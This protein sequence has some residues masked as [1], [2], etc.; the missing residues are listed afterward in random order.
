MVPLRNGPGEASWVSARVLLVASADCQAVNIAVATTCA[1][2]GV[3]NEPEPGFP[4]SNNAAGSVIGVPTIRF[5][6]VGF[7]GGLDSAPGLPRMQV[8]IA[9]VARV[10][11]GFRSQRTPKIITWKPSPSPWEFPAVGL[12]LNV[13]EPRQRAR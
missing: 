6:G 2:L 5:P 4:A 9:A 8:T 12:T 11:T 1:W 13:T 10:T 7:V 3:I